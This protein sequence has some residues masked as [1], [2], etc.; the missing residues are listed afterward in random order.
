MEID[1]TETATDPTTDI[2]DVKLEAVMET[3]E[4]VKDVQLKLEIRG[5]DDELRP[6][7]DTEDI[8]AE[9]TLANEM[10]GW[11][12]P[13]DIDERLSD[14]T[15]STV[16]PKRVTLFGTLWASRKR[17]L[18]EP[19]PDIEVLLI[20][21]DPAD[22]IRRRLVNERISGRPFFRGGAES[23]NEIWDKVFD[24]SKGVLICRKDVVL[25]RLPD[26]SESDDAAEVNI[27]DENDIEDWTKIADVDVMLMNEV[28][29]FIT[30]GT[31]I[32]R[33][34]DTLAWGSTRQRSQSAWK[35][36]CADSVRFE[37]M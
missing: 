7:I 6:M 11:S 2:I 37:M 19:P 4:T 30:A 27:I 5:A 8:T 33:G 15:D 26:R 3:P 21:T 23:M 32:H 24:D 18:L 9:F 12:C 16:R 10:K 29:L 20:K 35:T 14:D 17:R 36:T 13:P 31:A 25:I 34:E 1:D 28:L 22:D